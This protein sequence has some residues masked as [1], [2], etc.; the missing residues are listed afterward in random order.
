M[1]ARDIQI[2]GDWKSPAVLLYIRPQLSN[3]LTVGMA[4]G[5]EEEEEE[6]GPVTNLK[7]T[8]RRR[9]PTATLLD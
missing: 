6:D 5:E 1:S 4:V 9:P 2:H 8:A 3:R 7:A